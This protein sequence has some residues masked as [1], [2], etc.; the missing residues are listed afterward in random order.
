MNVSAPVTLNSTA[1]IASGQRLPAG[2]RRRIVTKHIVL[3]SL[4]SKEMRQR[5][6][7]SARCLLRRNRSEP[8]LHAEH[9]G[10]RIAPTTARIPIDQIANVPDEQLGLE[11][12]LEGLEVVADERISNDKTASIHQRVIESGADYRP[13]VV[14]EASA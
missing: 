12:M 6:P 10:A 5:A 13:G 9:P 1:F 11:G 7:K 14:M 4:I 8:R 2:S 3:P